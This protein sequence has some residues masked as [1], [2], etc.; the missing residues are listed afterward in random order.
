MAIGKKTGGRNKGTPNKR[1]MSTAA[2]MKRVAKEKYGLDDFDPLDL[3]LDIALD[4]TKDDSLRFQATKELTNYS[5]SK[6]QSTQLKVEQEE[7]GGVLVVPAVLSE[8][9]FRK[10]ATITKDLES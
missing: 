5:H 7:S 9:E 6:L 2:R 10:R 1:S 3:L 8:E 4:D